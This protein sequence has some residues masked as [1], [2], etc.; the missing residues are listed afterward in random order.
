MIKYNQIE[1][2]ICIAARNL[3]DGATV[4]VGTGAPCAAA[5]LA[6]KHILPTCASS[7]RPE[8][9]L[10]FFQLCQYLWVTHVRSSGYNG[11]FNA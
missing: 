3:E 5:M 10:L 1:L 9:W 6:Q 11:R 8:E 2:M 4:V 7:L